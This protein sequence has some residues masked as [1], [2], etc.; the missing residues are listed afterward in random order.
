MTTVAHK[1]KNSAQRRAVMSKLKK[2]G[3]KATKLDVRGSSVRARQFH[4]N[5]CRPGSFRTI[6]LGSEG[7][8]GVICRPKNGGGKTRIQSV[9]ISRGD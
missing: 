8:K 9:I 5:R 2:R 3:F 1:F 7:T 6:S 4:P